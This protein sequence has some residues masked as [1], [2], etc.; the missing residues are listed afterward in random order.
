MVSIYKYSIFFS[1]GDVIENDIISGCDK[2][3]GAWWTHD[4]NKWITF[5]SVLFVV[6]G[7]VRVSG[8]K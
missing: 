2:G 7:N 6:F 8:G 1:N 3:I 4:H 5:I